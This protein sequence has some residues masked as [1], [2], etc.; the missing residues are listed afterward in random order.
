MRYEHG[1]AFAPFVLDGVKRAAVR[2]T[3]ER[4]SLFTASLFTV[5][6]VA[7]GAITFGVM[8][9]INMA[10][11]EMLMIGAYATFVIQ[12]LVVIRYSAQRCNRL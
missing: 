9:V 12:N 3:V 2:Q 11:G 8:G 10:H 5:S 1:L 6:L 4:A 7:V